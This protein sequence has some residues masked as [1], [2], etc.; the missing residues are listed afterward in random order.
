MPTYREQAIVLARR[1]VRDADRRYVVF[2]K[3]HGKLILLAK[4]SR[5]G[6]SK[7]TPHMAT[8][9]VVDVMV[10]EGRLVDRLAGAS[11]AR[12]F[13][14]I[15][16]SFGKTALA[17]SFLLVVDALTRRE[18]PDRRVFGLLVDYLAALEASADVSARGG[19]VFFASGGGGEDRRP[20]LFDS[21]V[22]R[23]LDI[24]GFGIELDRCVA[25][26]G[27]LAGSGNGIDP[28]RGGAMCPRCR[29]GV[30]MP[31]SLFVISI[32]RQMRDNPF[33]A[34]AESVPSE[35][36]GI[37]D[38]FLAIHLEGRVRALGYLRKVYGAY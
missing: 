23:L 26:R 15:R 22:L 5:R 2:S 19:S 8:F 17:Q 20:P 29:S 14:G 27:A 21:A 3:E 13:P 35:I 33:S 7:M 16:E 37:A 4:G 1:P 10:A 34:V 28:G 36:G 25:C 12:A 24:L 9:G 11:L 18:S 38:L 32:L 6:T 31:V 30:D